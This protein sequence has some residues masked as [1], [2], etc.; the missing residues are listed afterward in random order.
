MFFE[1]RKKPLAGLSNTKREKTNIN[2]TRN[3]RGDITNDTIQ[4]IFL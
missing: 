4:I 2:K 1:K 3:K